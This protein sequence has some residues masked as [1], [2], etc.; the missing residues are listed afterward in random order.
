[1]VN[2]VSTS[3]FYS[4]SVL[5][6][7]AGYLRSILTSVCDFFATIVLT[8]AGFSALYLMISLSEVVA[9]TC[10]VRLESGGLL[11]YDELSLCGDVYGFTWQSRLK[12]VCYRYS[13]VG[14]ASTLS[15][16]N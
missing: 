11:K 1:M 8:A 4:G 7:L 3:A 2:G 14:M 10:E 9:R 12:G 13:K 15:A 6:D 16:T 5:T